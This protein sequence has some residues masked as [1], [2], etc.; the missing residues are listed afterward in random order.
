MDRTELIELEMLLAFLR[1]KREE[2]YDGFKFIPGF[3]GYLELT[4]STG[5]VR[6]CGFP[7]FKEDAVMLRT[8]I[9]SLNDYYAKKI[10]G[11]EAKIATIRRG[12]YSAQT[13]PI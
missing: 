1:Q 4:I 3:D 8:F 10:A 6:V 2:C 7:I 12:E 11:I 5:K 13:M 9:D